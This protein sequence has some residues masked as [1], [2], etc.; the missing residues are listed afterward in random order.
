MK[1]NRITPTRET[2][3]IKL[4][5]NVDQKRSRLQNIGKCFAVVASLPVTYLWLPLSCCFR[6]PMAK[7]LL[8]E[9]YDKQTPCEKMSETLT[10]GLYGMVGCFSCCCCCFGC[11]GKYGPSDL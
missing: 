3:V 6:H 10:V 1:T 2:I 9:K 8:V 4:A 7:H 11:C 5:E